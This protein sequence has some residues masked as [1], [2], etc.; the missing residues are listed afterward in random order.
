MGRTCCVPKLFWM[1]ETISVHNMLSPRFELGIFM[2]WTGDSMNNLTS[3][4][5][6]FD[7]KIRASGKDLPVKLHLNILYFFYSKKVTRRIF[8]VRIFLKLYFF[9]QK[10]PIHSNQAKIYSTNLYALKLY[11]KTKVIILQIANL[12]G[13]KK[14]NNEV[15]MGIF[16]ILSPTISE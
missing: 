8:K 1:S 14:P 2:L 9:F 16:C 15:L 3:Y 7:A 12:W 6:L 5:G 10:V 11:S 13:Q 4:R